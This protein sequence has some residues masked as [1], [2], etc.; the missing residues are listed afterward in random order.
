MFQFSNHGSRTKP[1]REAVIDNGKFKVVQVGEEDLQDY[2]QSFADSTNIEILVARAVNGEPELLNVRSGMYGDFTE[3]PSNLADMERV[4]ASA[5]SFYDSL[6]VEMKA[7]FGSFNDFI[8]SMNDKDFL[9]KAGF[10][11]PDDSESEVTE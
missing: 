1:V 7:E 4:M 3:L 9:I 10:V 5:Q 8:S 11:T 2:I 6:S